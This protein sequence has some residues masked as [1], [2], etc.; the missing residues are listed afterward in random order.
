[1]GLF[2]RKAQQIVGTYTPTFFPVSLFSGFLSDMQNVSDASILKYFLTV[3]ELQA[4][5]NFRSKVFSDMNIKARNPQTLKD[6]DVPDFIKTINPFQSQNQFLRQTSTLR[7]LFGDVFQHVVYG[8]DRTM[9]KAMYNLPPVD[10]KVI[11]RRNIDPF[12]ITERSELI[13]L[14]QINFAGKTIK[15]SP[16]E[17]IHLSDNQIE[18]DA[19]H[20]TM[21]DSKVRPLL[22]ALEN[23]KTAYEARGI[24]MGNSA[25]GILSNDTKDG[26]GSVDI[27]AKDSDQLQKDYRAKY[28]L[29]RDKWS[30]IMTNLSLKWQDMSFDISKLKLFEEVKAD[31]EVICNAYM[32][33]PAI[34][35]PDATHDNWESAMIQAYEVA[36]IDATEYMQKLNEFYQFK[37]LELYADYSHIKI[38]QGD[39][40][41]KAQTWNTATM[42]LDKALTAGAITVEQYQKVLMKIGMI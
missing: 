41:K 5:F 21:G 16:E 20:Y 29:S 19:D 24:L 37:N 3:P 7:D 38:L 10:A 4:V 13:Q 2:K 1:M 12:T 36:Q 39:L 30:L 6:L 32:L 42:A 15:Y 33:P 9:A 23:I 11:T 22:Q 40:Q 8:T 31:I 18:F 28:G 26:L 17:I 34:M 27:N 14:Y 35:N 25:L